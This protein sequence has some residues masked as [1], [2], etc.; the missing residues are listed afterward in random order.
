MDIDKTMKEMKHY[1]AD[2]PRSWWGS[3]SFWKEGSFACCEQWALLVGEARTWLLSF[4]VPDHQQAPP[5]RQ[6]Y[7]HT[8]V[9]GAGVPKV[10]KVTGCWCFMYVESL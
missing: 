4:P 10:V 9:T 6:S 1:G 8:I 5:R 3:G 2:V 7:R